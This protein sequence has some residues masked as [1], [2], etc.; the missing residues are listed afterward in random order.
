MP[1]ADFPIFNNQLPR[2]ATLDGIAMRSDVLFANEKG[3]E[4]Q[5]VQKRAR[6]Y[7]VS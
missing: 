2:T 3:E 1:A 6:S 7:C 5:S 4:K